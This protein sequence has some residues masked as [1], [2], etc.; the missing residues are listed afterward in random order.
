MKNLIRQS[1]INAFSLFTV[2]SFFSG[3]IIPEN[4]L[5]LI[6]VGAIFTLITVLVKPLIKL[7]LLPINLI[8]IGLF[9]WLASV[10]VLFLLVRIVDTISIIA[11]TSSPISKGG[12]SIPSI[13]L[14]STLS[15]V[16]VSFLLS[17]VFNL[18]NSI[19]V[20]D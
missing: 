2:A 17:L 5:D 16:L 20:E 15:L 4:L 10:I 12:F 6:W 9:R 11:F 8:T 13:H 1:L 19:L 3:L 7:F 14:T 18:F